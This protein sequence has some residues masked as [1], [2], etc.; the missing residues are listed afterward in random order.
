[1]PWGNVTNMLGRGGTLLLCLG[2]FS[3]QAQEIAPLRITSTEG[4]LELR[5]LMDDISSSVN[6]V[7]TSW[8][9]GSTREQELFILTHGYVYHPN[10]LRFDFGGGP[11]LF[12]E[13]LDTNTGQ[14]DSRSTR[15]NITSHAFIL[16]K[17]PYPV[18]FF[19]DRETSSVSPSLSDR[20]VV[21]NDHYGMGLSL[22]QPLTPV[23]MNMNVSRSTTEGSGLTRL[24][25][26]RVDQAAF[27]ASM[28]LGDDGHAQ[29][30]W[31][32]Y[33]ND[34][35]SGATELPIIPNRY[36]TRNLELQG[37]Y[38]FGERRQIR[39]F[40]LLSWYERDDQPRL[41]EIRFAPQIRW[42][43]SDA[44]TSSYSYTYL[45]RSQ[46]ATDTRDHSLAMSIDYRP[47]D[48]WSAGGRFKGGRN[49]TTGMSLSTLSAVGLV[50]Y[51]RD[52]AVGLLN[53]SANLGYER[54]DRQA[55][56]ETIPVY[57]ERVVLEGQQ[58]VALSREFIDVTTI[59]VW[60][61]DRTQQF[62][63]GSDYRIFVIGATTWIQRIATGNI[64]DGEEVLVDYTYYTGGTALYDSFS[65]DIAMDLQVMKH[66]N[67]YARYG[68]V[69]QTLREGLPTLP[70]N[71]VDDLM[72]G[73][74]L[75]YPFA[76]D[77]QAGGRMETQRHDADVGPYD[78]SMADAYLQAT[79][80]WRITL[81]F[82]AARI[83]TDYLDS[84]EDVDL[85]RVGVR[86]QARPWRRTRLSFDIR[87]EEDDGG[88]LER[89]D[90]IAST[91]FSWAFR[92]L[93]LTAEGTYT[94]GRLGGSERDKFSVRVV[95]G[96]D[97]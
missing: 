75:D 87:R 27:N 6:G 33:Q 23:L 19:Y 94:E 9:D 30:T 80:P 74:R 17:K 77:W 44:L 42:I 72:A 97:F 2:A 54:Y 81:R 65:Q 40:N 58:E 52:T 47:S 53:L 92:Q 25:D 14:R 71:S 5:Y 21:V 13:D 50:S 8:T 1:M 55:D 48:R 51:R 64:L 76:R 86:L 36:I 67:L 59:E 31:N 26:D 38:L 16:E 91:R 66:V 37:E 60:N 11:I 90:R 29:A 85:R 20:F 10:F 93:R 69:R 96:R 46:E 57:G 78:R 82:S 15:V 63:E 95:L 45:D 28:A 49:E 3:L 88:T 84:P 7:E 68:R 18:E 73:V 83:I 70:L 4:H 12:Q 24:I 39:S 62:V 22:R 35:R 34:S 32:W 89:R 41:R 43:H 56:A 79:F 61:E